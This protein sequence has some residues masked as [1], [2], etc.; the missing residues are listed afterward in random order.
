METSGQMG[1]PVP[2]TQRQADADVRKK[3][4]PQAGTQTV[5]QSQQGGDDG[6]PRFTDWASI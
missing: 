5:Q 3:P 2:A 6:A 1:A 4:A